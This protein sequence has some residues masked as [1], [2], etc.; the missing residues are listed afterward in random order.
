MKNDPIVAEV[1]RLREELAARFNYDIAAIAA[2]AR[3]RERAGKRRVIPEP[4]KKPAGNSEKA[5]SLK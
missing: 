1:R 4:P 3:K 2:D 5:S